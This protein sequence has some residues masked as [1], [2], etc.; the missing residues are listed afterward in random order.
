MT[1]QQ[2]E[3]EPEVESQIDESELRRELLNDVSV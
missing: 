1:T 2:T 3:P